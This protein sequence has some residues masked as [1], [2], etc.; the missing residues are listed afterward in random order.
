VTSGHWSVR[1]HAAFSKIAWCCALNVLWI[2][3]TV[4]GGVVLGIGPATV[5]ACIL[6][7]QRMRGESVHLRDFAATWRR[8]LVGGTVVVLPVAVVTCLLLANYT[9]FSALGPGATAARL[10]TFAALVLTVAAGAY[11]GPMY[12]HYDLPLR[13]YLGKAMRFALVRPASTVVLM[14]V[15]ATLSFASAAIPVLLVTVSVGAWLQTSTWLCVRFFQ[16][17][18]DRLADASVPGP[19]RLARA[20]PSEPL[21]MR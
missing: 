15:F 12:A 14:F 19:P 21:R 9:F 18:E 13:S 16:E 8:E 6:V 4:L 17:N 10:A 2:A 11:I 7:R 3:F 20:L 1:L 5:T